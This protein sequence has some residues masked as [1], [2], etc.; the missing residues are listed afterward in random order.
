MSPECHQHLSPVSDP[1]G[2]A[3][4]DVQVNLAPTQYKSLTTVPSDSSGLMVSWSRSAGHVDWYDLTLEDTVSNQTTRT[5]IM[6]SA[7]PQS[8]FR[9]LVPGTLYTVSVVATAGNKSAAPVVT[10]AA[11]GETQHLCS[12]QAP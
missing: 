7:A 12:P 11:T 5:R 1:V 4:L 3:R 9:S 8:G 6:G 10:L 2:P